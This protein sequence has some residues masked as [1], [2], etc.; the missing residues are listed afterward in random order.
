MAT[1]L[2]ITLLEGFQSIFIFL[3]I[4]AVVYGMLSFIQPFGKEN[5]LG[6][7]AFIGFFIALITLFSTPVLTVISV[8]TPWFVAITLFVFFILIVLFTLGYTHDDVH[9]TLIGDNYKNMIVVWVIVISVIIL[10]AGLGFVFFTE[11]Q[12]VVDADGNVVQV[13]E[14]VTA[15]PAGEVGEVG[16]DAFFATLFHP[17]VLGMIVVMIIGFLAITFL[18]KGGSK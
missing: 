15:I 13:V 16:P 5:K 3:L 12:L 18:A 7:Y 14:E 11:D 8:I 4:W 1:F 17:R 6:L 2:D 9:G 10:L